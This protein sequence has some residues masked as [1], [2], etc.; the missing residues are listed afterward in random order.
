M[1]MILKNGSYN[2]WLLCKKKNNT[3]GVLTSYH[4]RLFLRIQGVMSVRAFFNANCVALK[5]VD[6]VA[7]G[8]LSYLASDRSHS[9]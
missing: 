5:G 2:K 6:W 1:F 7:P 9:F 8:Q 3:I 4:R